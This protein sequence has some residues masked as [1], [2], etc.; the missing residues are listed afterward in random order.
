MRVARQTWIWVSSRLVVLSA[1][2]A[3]AVTSQVPASPGQN[4]AR[5]VH[6][7]PSWVTVRFFFT[8][9]WSCCRTSSATFAPS[10]VIVVVTVMGRSFVTVGNGVMLTSVIVGAA[11][12]AL[13]VAPAFAVSS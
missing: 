5:N 3:V 13:V 7:W 4:V 6:V 11:A 8:V 12:A 9:G 1:A 2:V 10:L